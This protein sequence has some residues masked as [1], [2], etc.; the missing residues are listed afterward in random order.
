MKKR[1]VV[2]AGVAGLVLLGG[3]FG[4][5]AFTEPVKPQDE[6]LLT[7]EKAEE[8]ALNEIDGTIHQVE[9][10]ED[11]G[12]LKYEVEVRDQNGNDDHEIEIDA[13]S[14]NVMEV[15]REDDYESV[16][17]DLINKNAQQETKVANAPNKKSDDNNQ[18]TKLTKEEAVAIATKA[19]P[20][21]VVE[22]EYDDGEYEIEI[23]TGKHE[24]DY[25]IDARTGKILEKDMDQFD[26]DRDDD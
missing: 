11:D 5:G 13:K 17:A 22:V 14:G 6:N 9:L 12:Q 19:T 1:N 18:K 3:A 24:V 21:K 20:G 15:D 2:I 16:P 8:K 4:V 7:I 26:D 25:E 10:E 23:H